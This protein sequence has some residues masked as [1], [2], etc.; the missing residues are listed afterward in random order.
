MRGGGR[1]WLRRHS[2]QRVALAQ[3]AFSVAD[4]SGHSVPASS[5]ATD[6]SFK[7]VPMQRPSAVLSP[8]ASFAPGQPWS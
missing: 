4:A 8:C 6:S 1:P 5:A 2:P 3:V 7:R